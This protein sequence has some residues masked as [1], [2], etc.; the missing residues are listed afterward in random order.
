MPL[1]QQMKKDKSL[2][3][4]IRRFPYSLGIPKKQEKTFEKPSGN[5]Y[6]TNYEKNLFVS[7]FT[8]IGLLSQLKN[9]IG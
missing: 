6:K 8:T 2:G 4:K 3:C 1:R 9:N 5:T 7:E